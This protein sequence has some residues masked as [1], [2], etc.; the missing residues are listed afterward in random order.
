M[1]INASLI[2]FV[3][4]SFS[5]CS[6]QSTCDLPLICIS[7]SIFLCLFSSM[8]QLL[9]LQSCVCLLSPPTCL[10]LYPAFS[11]I[12]ILLPQ[13]Q[14]SCPIERELFLIIIPL[15]HSICIPLDFLPLGISL[16]SLPLSP[17][18]HSSH[19]LHWCL[20]V[21]SFSPFVHVRLIARLSSSPIHTLQFLYFSLSPSC[22][23]LFPPAKSC[24]EV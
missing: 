8:Q 14:Q 9:L 10:F 18:I 22:F 23:F 2:H 4:H 21:S 11:F 17:Y 7:L 6:H 13:Q 20:P 12:H 24:N 1:N 15:S 3:L 16:L 19:F 5:L